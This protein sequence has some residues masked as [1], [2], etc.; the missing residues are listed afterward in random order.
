MKMITHLENSRQRHT[1]KEHYYSNKAKFTKI[2]ERRKAEKT[3][4]RT[5]LTKTD[6]DQRLVTMT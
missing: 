1:F 2:W 4:I 5:T 6:F 3:S